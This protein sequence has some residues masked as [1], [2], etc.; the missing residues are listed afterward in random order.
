MDI[1]NYVGL[2]L[3]KNEYCFLPG[4]G[5]LQIEKKPAVYNKETQ[6]MSS[7]QYEVYYRQDGGSIDDSFANFIAT[8]ERISIAHAANHLK[9]FCAQAKADLREGKSVIIPGIGSLKSDNNNIRFDKDAAL[10]I[11][12]RAIPYFR[13]SD[14]V[15]AKKEEAI[16][17]IIERTSFRE[18]KANEEIEY[19]AP[20][21]NWGKIFILLGIAI[22]IIAVAIFI[23][24]S[25]NKH[26][27]EE[28]AP[29]TDSVQQA[30]TPPPAATPAPD[31]SVKPQKDTAAVAA[32]PAANATGTIQYKVALNS[33]P[34]RK[35]A[36]GRVAKLKS[37]GHNEVELLA[38]DSNTYYVVIPVSSLASDTTKVVD[39][40][41]K[42]Y[43][44]KGTLPIIR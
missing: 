39:S 28:A 21:V 14:S 41:R 1:A 31:T 20:S 32:T 40:L 4:I 33:Y 29:S 24:M 17:N 9:D 44:P 30:V 11:E 7:P 16:S 26:K 22:V 34:T 2:F 19:K 36:E 23:F 37:F 6:Q 25:L 38:K 18:P 13:N 8:N 10:Q 27:K 3:L 43:N 12:G 15:T 5:S 42:L 35:G